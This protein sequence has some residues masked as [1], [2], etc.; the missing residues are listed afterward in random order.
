MSMNLRRIVTFVVII[1]LFAIFRP[2]GFWNE[3]K[4]I[5]EQRETITRMLF[6]LVV[7]YLLYGMYQLYQEG[8]L[9][10]WIGP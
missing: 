9:E 2:S 1:L 5:W 8:W 6:F 4:R 10:R 3:A 7:A